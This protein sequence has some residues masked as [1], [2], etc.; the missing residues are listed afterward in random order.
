MHDKTC[1]RSRRCKAAIL[2]ANCWKRADEQ[3]SLWLYN[4]NVHSCVHNCITFIS[5][6]IALPEQQKHRAV[7]CV[8]VLICQFMMSHFVLGIQLQ[9]Y[10]QWQ[11][12]HKCAATVVKCHIMTNQFYPNYMKQYTLVTQFSIMVPYQYQCDIISGPACNTPNPLCF[13]CW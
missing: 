7:L 11:C 4:Y 8:C 3:A 5:T 12:E 10:L 9:N 13:H 2:N 6:F 1:L